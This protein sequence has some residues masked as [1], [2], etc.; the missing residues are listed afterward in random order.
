[1]A[2][3]RLQSMSVLTSQQDVPRRAAQSSVLLRFL[4]ALL[5][6]FPLQ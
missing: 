2:I 4:A 6:V 3:E 5:Q 1:M